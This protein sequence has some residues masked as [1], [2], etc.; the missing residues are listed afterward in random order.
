MDQDV[1]DDGKFVAVA[2]G[3]CFFVRDKYVITYVSWALALTR[4]FTVLQYTL[5]VI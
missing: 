5:A 4:T 2:S 3:G 1:K